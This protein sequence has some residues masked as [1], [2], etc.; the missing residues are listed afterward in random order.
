MFPSLP[1]PLLI[2][3]RGASR[4]APENTMEAFDLA[5]R[6]GAHVLELDVRVSK[7]GVVVVMHD[8]TV[9]RTTSGRG[10]VRDLT[11]SELGALDA[12][13]HFEPVRRDFRFRG[14]G[15]RVPRLEEVL[16][17]YPKVGF[18]VEIKGDDPAAVKPVLDVLGHSGASH[19]LL[20]AHDAGVMQALEAARPGCALGLSM[21]QVREVVVAAWRGRSLEHYRGR[22][23]QIPVRD[24]RFA[25]GLLPIATRRVIAHAHAA[26]I[27]VHIWTLNTPS[28]AVRW[29][30][31]GADGVIT[32]DPSALLHL[33][34]AG[35]SEIA[36]RRQRT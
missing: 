21:V 5:V 7:D 16:A 26:G 25:Y 1:R 24:K 29:L 31:R 17:A 22:A 28:H 19:L 20:A 34:P 18:N 12:G 2:A 27:E 30:A 11:S 10:A 9:D 32:D 13:H 6:L 14:R 4:D 3:H 33:F 15:A 8:A 36:L 35:E 23:L